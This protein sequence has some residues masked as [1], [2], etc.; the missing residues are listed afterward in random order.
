MRKILLILA[1]LYVVFSC[2][3]LK[4]HNLPQDDISYAT[5]PP[6]ASLKDNFT[7]DGGYEILFH[8]NTGKPGKNIVVTLSAVDM[9]S[10]HTICKG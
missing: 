3:A 9:Y 10:D 5:N 7:I 1:F 6:R 4:D 2:F 8:I